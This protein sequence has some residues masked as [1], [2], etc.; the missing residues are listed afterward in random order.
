MKRR[1]SSKLLPR[2][3]DAC[4]LAMAGLLCAGWGVRLTVRD[5]YPAASAV[6]YA[7]PVPVLGG[8]AAGLCL[9]AVLRGRRIVAGVAALA[10]ATA[11]VGVLAGLAWPPP[12]VPAPSDLKVVFW[13]ASRPLG[14]LT[15]VFDLLRKHDADI[16][17]IVETG[18]IKGD[19]YAAWQGAF[20]EYR[21]AR[22]RSSGMMIL[23]KGQI[24]ETEKGEL[25]PH[26]EYLRAEI[27]VRGEE[28]TIVLVDLPASPLRSREA[29]FRRLRELLN[30]DSDRKLIL[31]GDFNTPL[32]S[33]HFDAL[34]TRISHAFETAGRGYG[35]TWP[36]PV[37]VLALDHLWVDRALAVT[38]CSLGFSLLSD[39]RLLA[40][41]LRAAGTDP[42][43]RRDRAASRSRPR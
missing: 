28:F 22:K 13:N 25:G 2:A 35:A 18:E 6:F 20:P 1:S 16:L 10:A 40:A 30:A 39:H 31:M 8:L 23:T 41:T 5:T 34:R 14:A 32:D 26:G 38:G 9:V 17:G 19:A 43:G 42:Q 33:V 36:V 12:A 7:T 21:I 27:R 29:H 3:L 4:A 11:V 15:K 24:V 37:P